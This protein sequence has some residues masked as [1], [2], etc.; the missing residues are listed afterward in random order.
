MNAAGECGPAETLNERCFCTTLDRRALVR[1]LEA[2]LTASSAGDVHGTIRTDFFAEVPLF[3]RRADLAT[4]EQAAQSIDALA[5][6]PS[7]ASAVSA[8]MSQIAEHDFGPLGVFM[9][10]DFHLTEAGPRLIEINTNAGGAFLN[11]EL[12]RAQRA[13]CPEVEQALHSMA[14][15]QSFEASVVEMFQSEWRRQRG[16]HP[17]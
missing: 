17:V 14:E 10:Y 11:A 12:A 6:N 4:M 13:C 9:G 8:W 16:R 2:Q 1:H 15:L 3:V 5:R 7:Y